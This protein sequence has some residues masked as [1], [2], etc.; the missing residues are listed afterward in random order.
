MI[1]CFY[2]HLLC[3]GFHYLPW[4][5]WRLH[6]KKAKMR[7]HVFKKRACKDLLLPCKIRAIASIVLDTWYLWNSTVAQMRALVQSFNLQH[8]SSLYIVW[9][10][11]NLQKSLADF[12]EITPKIATACVNCSTKLFSWRDFWC[13]YCV[14]KKRKS[15]FYC[16]HSSFKPHGGRMESKMKKRGMEDLI[17]VKLQLLHGVSYLIL[18]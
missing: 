18:F 6:G 9:L 3:D 11:H 7:K 14:E 16:S 4:L 12:R 15:S 17:A 10:G 1:V 8:E 13:L 5:G 2:T